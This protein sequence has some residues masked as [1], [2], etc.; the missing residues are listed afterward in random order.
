MFVLPEKGV[1]NPLIERSEAVSC[2][3]WD[4]GTCAHEMVLDVDTSARNAR[5]N[6]FRTRAAW[7]RVHARVQALP[8]APRIGETPSSSTGKKKLPSWD[9]ASLFVICRWPGR[10]E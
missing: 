3:G 4:D 5:K 10:L 9:P 6:I 8:S 7:C 2:C 1:R